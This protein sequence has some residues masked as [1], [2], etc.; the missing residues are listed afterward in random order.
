MDIILKQRAISVA[1]HIIQTGQTV[2]QT[3]CV[4][5][6]SKSTVHNDVSKRLPK[7]DDSLYQKVQFVLQ[8]NFAEKHIRG[9]LSTQKKFLSVPN[10]NKNFLAQK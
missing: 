3:A 1:L 7:I 2:R 8:K 5:G 4:Y 10:K 9:G 6:I